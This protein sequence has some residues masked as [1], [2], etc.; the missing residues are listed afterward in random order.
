MLQKFN[1]YFDSDR[2]VMVDKIF[3]KKQLF[4]RWKLP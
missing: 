3:E 1:E 2:E 4:L